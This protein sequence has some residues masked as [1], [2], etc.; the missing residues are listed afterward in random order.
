MTG[1]LMPK[2]DEATLPRRAE[3]VADVARIVPGEGVVD[4]GRRCAP[5]RATG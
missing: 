2:P 4:A 3:I 1:L 5:M